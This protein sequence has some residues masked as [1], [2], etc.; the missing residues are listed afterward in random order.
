MNSDEQVKYQ[1]KLSN[2]FRP[3]APVD[4]RA[5][6]SGRQQQVNAVLNATFQ[7]GQHVIMFGERG[8]GKTSLART[9]ADILKHAGVTPLSSGTINCDGTDDFSRLWHKVFRELQVVVKTELPGFSTASQ[10]VPMNLEALLPEKASPDDV[11]FAIIQAIKT[12]ADNKQMIIILDEVDRITRRN[13]TT[14]L[15]DTIKNLSDHLVPVTIILIGVADAVDQLIAEHKS[16]ERSIVQVQMPR[17]SR[18]ELAEVIDKGF[19]HATMTIA[20]E[21]KDEII[22]VSRG[23]PH[24]T[25]LLS[26][27]SALIAIG[28]DSTKVEKWDVLEA[29]KNAVAKSHS[30]LSDYLKAT[31]SPQKNSLFEEVLLAC[32]I[33]KKDEL[34]WFTGSNVVEPLS[35]IMGKP[36][37]LPYFARHLADFSS[38]R[39][40]HVLQKGGTARQHR[41]RFTNPLI[42]PFTV[43]RAMSC[44][45]W[46]HKDSSTTPAPSTAPL[47][48]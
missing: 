46:P 43:I 32:A 11:R 4:S 30:H 28:R 12:A 17:M 10:E 24:F 15:A 26:L 20:Q 13:V 16:V 8:V 23:L 18:Q 31:S 5:L 48:L 41:Y 21:A 40:G 1:V 2:V 36:Y 25:H 9:L 45:L 44:G 3:G 47:P 39:R 35:K 34:G 27:E 38:E 33:A 29:T 6:F 14:L 22:E 7:P 37:S 19:K 42:E